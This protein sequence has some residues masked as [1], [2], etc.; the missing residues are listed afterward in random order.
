MMRAG[1]RLC[2]GLGVLLLSVSTANAA[3]IVTPI[4]GAVDATALANTLASG[5]SGITINSATYS[6][7]N[8]ASG[9]FSGGGPIIGITSGM[10]LT[11]GSVNNVVG[12][13]ND[14]GA[15]GI[16]GVGG[17]AALSAIAGQTTFDASILT[18]NFTPTGNNISFSYVFGSE[19][20]PEYVNQFNDVFAFFVNGTNFALIPGTSTPVSINTVNSGVNSGFFVNNTTG[21]R[22]TQ[23][24]G[25]TTV[26]SFVAPVTPNVQN[27]LRLAIADSRDSILDSAVFL[28]GGSFAVCGTPGQPACPGGGGGGAGGGGGTPV[29]EP[30]SL[31]LILAGFAGVSKRLRQ[32]N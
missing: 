28:Q 4:G 15:T 14:S 32:R 20:Y 29:P 16:N 19:E 10:L 9:L 2:V 21:V 30:A 13:N 31:L 18:I 17:D 3:L 24:D 26:L 27:T 23:L 8:I 1:V 7:A 25:F 12:P 6:G 11:S 22:D 5:G